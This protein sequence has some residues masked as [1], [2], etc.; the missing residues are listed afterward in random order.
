M[1]T[2]ESIIFLEIFFYIG[3][4]EKRPLAKKRKRTN[5]ANGNDLAPAKLIQIETEPVEFED[6]EESLNGNLGSFCFQAT[7]HLIY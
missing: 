1:T 3:T 7:F 6:S 2:G 4:K 5:K